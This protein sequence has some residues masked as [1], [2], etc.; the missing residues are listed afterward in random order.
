MRKKLDNEELERTTK[1]L[2][3]RSSQNAPNSSTLVSHYAR[4]QC[5]KEPA[6]G[7]IQERK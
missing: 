7:I 6:Q 3:F 1:V 2:L 4:E 5:S